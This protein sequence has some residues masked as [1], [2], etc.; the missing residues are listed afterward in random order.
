MRFEETSLCSF[1][2]KI[3]IVT[4]EILDVYPNISKDNAIAIAKL[5][6][7]FSGVAN[8]DIKFMRYYYMLLVLNDNLEMRSI[9]FSE[10]QNLISEGIEDEKLFQLMDE[11][12]R[13]MYKERENFPIISEVYNY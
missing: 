1:E 8:N 6:E 9:I 12:N 5:D 13:Y 10:M 4:K 3:E 7:P 2:E 11:I